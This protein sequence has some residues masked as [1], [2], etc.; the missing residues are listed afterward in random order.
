MFDY[1]RQAIRIS[2][3]ALLANKTR[4][5]LTMLGIIIGV[6]A[7]IVIMAVGAGAQSLILA[8]IQSLGSNLVGVLPGNSGEDGPP[9]SAMG[10]VITTLTYD[11]AMALKL[12]KNVPNLEEVAAYSSAA[13]TLE[14]GSNSFEGT[15]TGTTDG[16]LGVEGGEVESGRFFTKD[17]ERNLSKVV[18]LGSEVKRDL[19]GDSEAIGQ[20]IKIKKH[21][22]EVIGIMKERGTVAF[23]DYDD[24]ILAPIITVQ[25]LI[26]GVHHIGMIRAK[27]DSPDNVDRAIE[28]IKITLRERHDITNQ[29]GADD[30][31]TARSAAQALDM[32]T[33]ITDAL[34][35]FLAAMAALSLLVGGIGIMNIMLVSVTERTR[36][37]GLR[38]AVGAN[39]GNIMSQFLLEAITVTLF[40]GVIGIVCGII[41]SFVISVVANYLGYNWSFVVS[42]LSVF[43]AVGVSAIVGLVFGLYPAQKASRLEPVE[44]L[45]YE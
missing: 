13:A 43:L 2:F 44:A 12:K 36:E 33:V 14:W 1:Y 35:Y 3:V 40:G 37:I 38:K 29:S 5:F 9:T 45:R 28:D 10:I 19:F 24:K 18:V 27:V 34:K 23:Q 15:L 6:G 30:D 4:S 17:E 20:R 26:A 41:I 21:Y 8:Q 7:V 16:Y 39:N 22:F 31:F 11:D 25:K 32:I 42:F